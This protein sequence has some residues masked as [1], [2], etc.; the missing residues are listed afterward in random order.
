MSSIVKR[1][2]YPLKILNQNREHRNLDFDLSILGCKEIK[3]IS[4]FLF[5]LELVVELCDILSVNYKHQEK[6]NT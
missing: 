2:N 3:L 6:K 5:Y 4:N 1:R